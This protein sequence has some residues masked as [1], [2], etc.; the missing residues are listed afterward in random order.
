MTFWV[1]AQ[2]VLQGEN[3]GAVDLKLIE[4]TMATLLK[5]P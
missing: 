3:L 2:G 5:N 1:D 4:R